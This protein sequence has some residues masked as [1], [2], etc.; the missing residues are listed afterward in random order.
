MQNIPE[1]FRAFQARQSA[2]GKGIEAGLVDLN[3]D[4]LDAGDVLIQAKYS[5]VNYKDALGATGKGRIYKKLPIVGGIDVSGT[6][7]ASND[8]SLAVGSEVLVT[9]CGLG[10]SHDGGYS[11][12]VRVPASWVIPL[13]EG[14]SLREAMI[15]GT[16]GFTAGLCV[17]RLQVNDQTPDKGPIVVTGA[18][19]GVGSFA[20]QMLAKQ[21]FDVIAVSGKADA[22]TYLKDLGAK[23]VVRPEDLELGERPLE[24]VRFGGAIDNVGG[25][26]LEGLLRHTNLWGNIAS[27]G[28]AA[29][30]RFQN[31]VMPFILR[32]V[33]LLGI[34]SANCPRSL[35]LQIWKNLAGPLK[36]DQLEAIQQETVRLE[37]LATVFQRMIDRQIR[38]RVLVEIG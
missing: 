23:E 21:G 30:F 17:H 11:E 14:L 38:G 27:V 28:L 32:G 18:S 8:P 36:P 2:Q 4:Q 16:A 6:V 1:K 29:D 37:D 33:S 35:R 25:S 12:Y 20:I 24:S 10:E 9:G 26:L 13:P 5:S 22:V 15:Y 31:T 3:A 34:S 7:V 19:G